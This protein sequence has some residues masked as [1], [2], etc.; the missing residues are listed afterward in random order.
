MENILQQLSNPTSLTV[1]SKSFV[2][3]LSHVISSALLTDN[4]QFVHLTGGFSGRDHM[5]LVELILYADSGSGADNWAL[6]IKSESSSFSPTSPS[7][8]QE[9]VLVVG[10]FSN[11]YV[12]VELTT[13]VAKGEDIYLFSAVDCNY[14]LSGKVESV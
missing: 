10:N 9:G 7:L 6:A 13:A 14:R 8:S 11:K 5:E 2:T 4:S 12:R 1:P 3:P